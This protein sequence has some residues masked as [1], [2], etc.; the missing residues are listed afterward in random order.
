MSEQNVD[1]RPVVTF[2]DVSPGVA[3]TNVK[4]DVPVSEKQ[5]T[6]LYNE[7]VAGA[8]RIGT[9]V[10]IA[11]TGEVVKVAT[12]VAVGI[13]QAAQPVVKQ[14][15]ELAKPWAKALGVWFN[16]QVDQAKANDKS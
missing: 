8:V 7:K 16:K 2:K 6:K 10:G 13:G 4:E 1:L 9:S 14:A 11:G 5:N 3:P 12:G 15:I